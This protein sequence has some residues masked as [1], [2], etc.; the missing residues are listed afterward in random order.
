MQNQ[1]KK[2]I[3]EIS[4]PNKKEN[5]MKK[6]L[7][8]SATSIIAINSS[9]YAGGYQLQEY[10]VTN[11]G[12]SFAGAG[13]VGDDYS[14]LAFNPAGMVLK[15]SGVQVGAIGVD[16][17]S[18]ITGTVKNGGGIALPGTAGKLRNY[19][20]L[21]HFFGQYNVNDKVSLGLG[22]YVPFGLGTYYNDSWF[23]KTHALDSEIQAIDITPAIAFKPTKWLSLGGSFIAEHVTA[24]LTNA[25]N[26]TGTEE[27]DMNAKGWD[28]G[29]SAGIMLMP[30][31]KTRFGISY[32]EKIDHYIEDDHILEKNGVTHYGK[33]S[34]T[35]TFPRS[36]QFSAFHNIGKFDLTAMARWT[37]WTSFGLLDIKSTAISKWSLGLVNNSTV[38]ENWRNVWMFSGGLDYHYS[39]KW[40]FRTGLGHDRGA[41]RD[42][43]HRTARV[44]DAN[45][46]IASIGASYMMNN[47]QFDLGYSHV[48]WQ[49][50]SA[51]HTSGGTKLDAT[52]KTQVNIF[53]LSAQYKF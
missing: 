35:L 34:T 33:S 46:W 9:L 1:E 5:R 50:A 17:H 19:A 14:A 28:Y 39:D 32:R 53:G 45:R 47:W 20:T 22:V 16:I 52:Y 26:D 21:P 43:D 12:R 27:S 31:D 4:N 2:L 10:S 24:N 49:E 44:P 11:L 51:T 18:D 40:T 30:S 48:F 23:G 25:T 36:V 41:V 6:I 7:A 15:E 38:N 3:I 13:I 29:W 37:E 8:V 42:S